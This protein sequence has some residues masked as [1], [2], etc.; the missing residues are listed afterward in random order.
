M[1]LTPWDCQSKQVY[2][3]DGVAPTLWAG[4]QSYWGGQVFILV[5]DD[6]D[7]CGKEVLRVARGRCLSDIEE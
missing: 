6:E 4:E 7:I 3:T 5:D 2:T 1:N